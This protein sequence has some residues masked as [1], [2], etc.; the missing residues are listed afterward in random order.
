MPASC[1]HA[2]TIARHL[3]P[4]AARHRLFHYSPVNPLLPVD[5][6]VV[7]S[8]LLAVNS[9]LARF[10]CRMAGKRKIQPV[11]PADRTAGKSGKRGHAHEPG[12]WPGFVGKDLSICIV[13]YRGK[14]ISKNFNF[15][16]LFRQD[17]VSIQILNLEL[18]FPRGGRGGKGTKLQMANHA[19]DKL[20]AR[21]QFPCPRFV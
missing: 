15:P 11:R 7:L 6:H 13:D 1:M 2:C 12:N 4:A 8:P 10:F 18:F 16:R 21:A 19:A 20:V 17:I 9:N 5:A 3:R 14:I